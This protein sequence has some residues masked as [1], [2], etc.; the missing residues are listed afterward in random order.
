MTLWLVCLFAA[1]IVFIRAVDGAENSLLSVHSY[2]QEVY[3]NNEDFSAGMEMKRNYVIRSEEG[4]LLFSPRLV[5][6]A[7]DVR[8]EQP[9]LLPDFPIFL[10]QNSE[11][12][13]R[14]Y[15]IGVEQETPIGFQWKVNSTSSFFELETAATTPF[16]FLNE[17]LAFSSQTWS[18]TQSVSFKQPLWKNGFGQRTRAQARRAK[19]DALALAYQE[20]FKL[21]N[22]TAQ[23]ENLYW[24][25]VL[26]REL[27]R[28]REESMVQAE[29][30][31]EFIEKKRA[32]SL[33]LESEVYQARSLLNI[34]K[35]EY[36]KA[37]ES[38]TAI[39]LSFNSLRGVS[40]T[41][42]PETLFPL[43]QTIVNQFPLKKG[44]RKDVKAH[45]EA[46]KSQE[47]QHIIAINDLSPEFDVSA[48]FGY[49]GNSS[50]F[51]KSFDESFTHPAKSS[52]V[53]VRLSIP[54]APVKIHQIKRAYRS[55][56][57][58][59]QMNLER[60]KFQHDQE[61]DDLQARLDENKNL[62]ELL[63]EN[64]QIQKA[65]FE[66]LQSE[67]DR[68]L[69]TFF[70]VTTAFNDYQGSKISI[71]QTFGVIIELLLNLGLY[72]EDEA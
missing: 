25:L 39:A 68:G 36:K 16:P 8:K 6:S 42:V 60:I 70:A 23:A 17:L 41:E 35:I 22:A 44:V 32:D 18:V 49:T 13:N 7:R 47:A 24:Q 52:A 10:G 12:T 57:H 15:A 45:E 11:L 66:N 50:H 37:Q 48:Y 38:E 40:S 62:L 71:L 61:W 43:D 34:S 53:L 27:T 69:T 28:I 5:T 55:S 56:S 46:L 51:R 1:G 20:S 31:M 58:S 2:L 29:M 67:Y 30:L 63:V 4:S 59:A 26:A 9:Q 21:K 54:I 65:K 19:Y 64:E 3:R 72:S 33:A 14:E